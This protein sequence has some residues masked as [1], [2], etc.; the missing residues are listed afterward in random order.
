MRARIIV[1]A[2]DFGL[3]RGINRAIAELHACGAVTSATLMAN[4]PA[5]E[6]AV[7]TAKAFPT[8]GVGCHIVL[9][10]GTPVSPPHTVPT[11]LHS[12]NVHLRPSLTS[13]FLAVVSGKV[14][15][16]DVTR[17]AQT[18]ISRLQQHGI[19][20]THLDTH[21]HT[22]M[23]PQIARPLLNVAETCGIRSIRNPFEPAWCPTSGTTP[24]T[25]RLQ[26]RLLREFRPQFLALPQ[27]RNGTIAT[28][29]GTL[30]IASTGNLDSVSIRAILAAMRGGTWELVCH[31]GYNDQDLSGITT[32]L[33]SS[34]EKERMALA[35]ALANL[36]ADSPQPRAFQS[37]NYKDLLYED[38]SV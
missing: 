4:G 18:Q 14:D 22:H 32:R 25:R 13:F 12:D 17:E 20:P 37:I 36:P 10:D 3:T 24:P 15:P 8:L 7:R 11:L 23:L 16:A 33:R 38:S 2:D 29:E 28:T 19:Q 9:T 26:L 30:G 1:N 31:P 21:K 35:E 6:D 34:R 27:I 5:F